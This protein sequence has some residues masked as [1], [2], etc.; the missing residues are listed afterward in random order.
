M[1]LLRPAGVFPDPESA[2]SDRGIWLCLVFVGMVRGLW[3]PVVVSGRGLWFSSSMLR[4]Y[5]RAAFH[6]IVRS[7]F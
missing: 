2:V 6:Y 4:S 1:V 5:F 7:G 3:S